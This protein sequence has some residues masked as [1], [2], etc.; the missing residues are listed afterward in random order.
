MVPI[1][2]LRAALN[3]MLFTYVVLLVIGCGW[4]VV[5]FVLSR[6]DRPVEPEPEP[7]LESEQERYWEWD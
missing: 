7:D 3:V 1:E 4:L 2:I 6:E 5:W